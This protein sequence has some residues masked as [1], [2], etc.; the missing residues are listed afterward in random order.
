MAVSV[1]FRKEYYKM[2]SENDMRDDFLEHVRHLVE[3]WNEIEK[4]DTIEKLEGL[5]FSILVALDGGSAALPGY[6][7]IPLGNSECD[8]AGSLHELFFQHRDK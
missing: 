6:S 4:E 5:A 7:V 1:R 2:A 3:Y 8:I